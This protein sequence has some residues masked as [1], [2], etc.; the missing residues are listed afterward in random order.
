MRMPGLAIGLTAPL[1]LLT[2]A[3]SLAQSSGSF[4]G[5]FVSVS[6]IPTIVCSANDPA[7]SCS[8]GG[9]AFLGATIKAPGAASKNI[10]IG[11]SLQT[12][13]YTATSATGGKGNQSSTATGSIVVTP[14]VTGPG[15]VD[16]PVFPASVIFNERTQTL[17]ANL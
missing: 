17:S 1:L 4:A 13:L 7:L 8:N 11:G 12:A 9:T 15:G 3:S 6:I 10:L 14:T 16:V 5:D 2:A